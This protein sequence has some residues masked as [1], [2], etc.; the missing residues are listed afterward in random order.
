[1]VQPR[2]G[3]RRVSRW[4]LVVGILLAGVLLYLAFRGVDWR[5][6][7]AT[8]RR[9]RI[10]YLTLAF[11]ILST[12]YFL[13]GLR[14]RILLSAEKPIPV[15]TSFWAIVVGYLGNSFL[16]A[17]AGEFIRSAMLSR[18]TGI[19]M[20]Y[21][22]ATALTERIMDL[23]ALVCLSLVALITLETTPTW[24]LTAARTMAIFGL[25]GL[26]GL[27]AAPHIEDPL[28]RL[29]GRLLVADAPRAKALNILDQF[30]LGMRAVRH[31]GRASSFV[32]LTS[33]IWLMD[34]LVAITVAQALGL[35]LT[36]PQALLLLAALGLASAAPSA[37]GYIGIYQFVAVTV[38]G[39]FDFSRDQALIYIIAFQAVSYAVVIIWGLLGI[40]QLNNTRTTAVP[41]SKQS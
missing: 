5:A 40:W 31:V 1:M 18:D 38:L 17:R 24:L 2:L 34:G 3:N 21:V 28:K 37:P 14:W 6:M 19:S 10:D 4:S 12:S 23:I 16:P 13:R 26:A 15:L 33:V 30:L 11:L 22:L 41:L 32:G 25:F 20:S 29:L 39:P 35:A 36:L 8:A 27:F 7:L 9:G